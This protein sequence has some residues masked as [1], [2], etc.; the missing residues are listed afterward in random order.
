M[1]FI[2]NF[3]NK[4]KMTFITSAPIPTFNRKDY[5]QSKFNQLNLDQKRIIQEI[6][7]NDKINVCIPTGTGK[8]FM[9]FYDILDNIELNKINT[10]CIA[11][12]RLML[13][14]QHAKEIFDILY[15]YTGEIGYIIVGSEKI[16]IT[17][18]N[19]KKLYNLCLPYLKSK[20][21]NFKKL[22]KQTT[23]QKD[24]NEWTKEFL[25]EGKKVIIIST[26]QSLSC[27][28]GVTIDKIYCDEAHILATGTEKNTEFKNSFLS[29]NLKKSVFFTATPK[30][31][32][33]KTDPST[34]FLMNNQEIFG[35]R[36]GIDYGECI[37]KGYIVKP[38]IHLA[39]PSTPIIGD[40]SVNDKIKFVQ[41]SFKS[42]D[43]FVNSKCITKK[44]RGKMLVKCQ[45]VPEMWEVFNGLKS[46]MGD[47][48]IAAGASIGEDN[49][50]DKRIV[51]D[52]V[53]NDKARYLDKLKSYGED[54]PMI[55]LHVQTMTEGININNFTGVLF[56]LKILPTE[57]EL[58][59]NIGRG[60]RLHNLDRTN[61]KS[62]K[63]STIDLSN[64]AKPYCSV[65]IPFWDT[66]TANNSSNIS[67]KI[68]SI[69]KTSD[70]KF[71]WA[72]SLGDDMP[73]GQ[74][75]LDM[76]L[77]NDRRKKKCKDIVEGI[78]NE[79]NTFEV[80]DE[81]I[82]KVEEITRMKSQGFEEIFA[83]LEKNPLF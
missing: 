52:L 47:V 59:Q 57:K 34:S 49:S 19:D 17:E 37:A 6:D 2:T 5:L 83:D 25:S 16:D 41:E 76:P 75:E 71:K 22:I 9:M 21:T 35:I 32:V 30:D 73:I 50:N 26:Y 43:E 77:L 48:V 70:Y 60:M 58:I 18:K 66:E 1:N 12:H 44:L 80:D 51:N 68:Y 24:V 38:I 45:G 36:S 63:I 29:L 11:T 31:V 7:S 23:S 10:I 56:L 53:I 42:H 39:S 46:V 3:L 27:V 14:D 72:V 82:R 8:G 33:E 13:N 65:I 55:V 15:P 20:R 40:I 78:K 4:I 61:L 54:I 81:F 79:I 64:W 62:G 74:E 28:K 69:S 67:K